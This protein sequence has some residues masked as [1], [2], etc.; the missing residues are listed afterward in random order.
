[1]YTFYSLNTQYSLYHH[2]FRSQCKS[3]PVQ[4]VDLILSRILQCYTSAEIADLGCGDAILAQRLD[5]RKY[6]VHSF[7]LVGSDLVTAC[8]M[9][10]TPLKN[11]QVDVAV[12]CLSLMGT[13]Y[14]EFLKEAWRISKYGGKVLIAEVESRF[15]GVNDS[16]QESIKNFISDMEKIGFSSTSQPDRSHK[17]FVSMEFEKVRRVISSGDSEAEVGK[18]LKPCLYKKR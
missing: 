11:E 3:W 5:R 16:Y 12:F 15:A 4:P 10:D 8:D 1:M 13:N 18:V 7:D 6:T 2:G 17:V 9:S 14:H